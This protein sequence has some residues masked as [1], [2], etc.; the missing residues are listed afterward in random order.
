MKNQTLRS[1]I[2]VAVVNI[3]SDDNIGKI[4]ILITRM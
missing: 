1:V 3:A 2:M 4:N